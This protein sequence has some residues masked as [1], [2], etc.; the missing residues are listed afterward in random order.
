ALASSPSFDPGA[1]SSLDPEVRAQEMARIEQSPDRPL[2]NHATQQSLPPGSTMKVITTA[3]ALEQGM[4][5]ETPV[6]GADRTLLPG[7]STYLEN[8]AGQ[9]CGGSTVTLRTA[10]ERS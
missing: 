3:A 5:P 2:L 9:T 10:L 4:G 6:S 1:L 8:Y 7:T